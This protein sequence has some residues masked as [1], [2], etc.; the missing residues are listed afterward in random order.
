LQQGICDDILCDGNVGWAENRGEDML[1]KSSRIS[2]AA[3]PVVAE[4]LE[5]RRLLSLTAFLV[6]DIDPGVGA[7]FTASSSQIAAVGKKI[8]F[9]ATDG[10]NGLQ[11]WVSDGTAADTVLVKNIPSIKSTGPQNLTAGNGVVFFTGAD[12]NGVQQ[13]WRSD[14]TAA[15]TFVV[16][17]F[18]NSPTTQLPENL[19]FDTEAN[20]LF[21]GEATTTFGD[22]ALWKTNATGPAVAKLIRSDIDPQNF[23]DS[24]GF[25][26]F[27]GTDPTHGQELWITD[28]SAHGTK[29]LGDANPGPDSSNIS[30]IAG[31]SSGFAL[32][33]TNISPD[34]PEI[35]EAEAPDGMIPGGI[36]DLS[37]II[38]VNPLPPLSSGSLLTNMVLT[39]NH[40]AFV[41]DDGGG[42]EIWD[43]SVTS[44]AFHKVTTFSTFD[45]AGTIDNL[46]PVGNNIFFTF[47]DMTGTHLYELDKNDN[48]SELAGGN[49]PNG[50]TNPN[51]LVS[52]GGVLYFSAQDNSGDSRLFS[53]D[54]KIITPVGGSGGT[55]PS[56]IINVNGAAFYQAS[57]D[58][59]G[60]ELHEVLNLSIGSDVTVNQ[61]DTISFL[62]RLAGAT[63][64]SVKWDL[65]GDGI[66]E[67]G[68]LKPS[69][70]YSK[71]T[72]SGHPIIVT[73]R[74]VT[75]DGRILHATAKVTVKA[76]P[77]TVLF[78]SS[79][80]SILPYI[81]WPFTITLT[82]YLGK[83]DTTATVVVDFDDG[84]TATL[85][86]NSKGIITGTHTFGLVL[87]SASFTRFLTAT[88]TDTDGAQ[89]MQDS[90]FIETDFINDVVS[91]KA[92]GASFNGV[93]IGG[94]DGDDTITVI[95]TSGKPVGGKYEYLTVSIDGNPISFKTAGNL[96]IFTGPG[97]DTVTIDPAVTANVSIVGGD[98]NDSLTGGAGNDT[99]VGNAG[100]DELLGGGGHN[101]IEP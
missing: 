27:L 14:G 16:S 89:T 67:T 91:V 48:A 60:R 80:L 97:D 74:V 76:V 30:E 45:G 38:T 8:F 1:E 63:I 51:D 65:D 18:T 55:D 39:N 41:A 50:G 87:P 100:A 7:G 44:P 43:F 24:G 6:S 90:D 77:P 36:A 13:V 12:A 78:V 40:F 68:G 3:G 85:H 101:T 26:F 57:D 23:V 73:A 25:I 19:L 53:T 29:I 99:L 31:G 81:P 71:P 79:A 88:A 61:G 96:Y 59:A 4:L 17:A 98:G 92:L 93:L 83:P 58:T 10:K 75:A 49:L 70:T 72:K 95:P 5:S 94:Y 56:N 22:D 66:Y 32:F 34:G 54:G 84:T 33:V 64:G 35:W 62:A 20:T 37:E 86:P 28:G 46:I 69:I 9:S 82:N 42:A 15:G 47:S 52:I 2:R 21:F 11:L